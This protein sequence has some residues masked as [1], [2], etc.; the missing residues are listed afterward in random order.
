M[1]VNTNY[2]DKLSAKLGDHG[3]PTI[4]CAI[5]KT[6]IHNALCDLGPL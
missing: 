6:G 5:G 2:G 3:I 1:A 4:T